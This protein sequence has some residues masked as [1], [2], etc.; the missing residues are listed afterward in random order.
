VDSEQRHSEDQD[1]RH[2][3]VLV[4]DGATETTPEAFLSD[5]S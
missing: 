5:V 4:C 3:H 2:F 1:E